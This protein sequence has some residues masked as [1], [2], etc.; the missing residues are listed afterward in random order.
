MRFISLLLAFIVWLPSLIAAPPAGM[1]EFQKMKYGFFVHYVW[2][3]AAYSA[4]ID[5]DGSKPAGLDD[6]ADR[7]DA[8]QFA[9]DLAAMKVEYVVFTAFHANMNVLYPSKVMDKWLPGHSAKRDL[10]GDMIKACK[11]KGIPVLFYTH[12]RDGHDF[13]ASEQARTGW[14]AGQSPN[15]DFGKWDRTNWNDFVNEVYGELVDRYGNDI[16]GLYLDEGSAAADSY[17][18]VDYPRLR[19]T[20]SAKHPQLLLM[21]ND[22]GDLYGFDI[23]NREVFYNGSYGTPDGNQW[24]SAKKP[25]SIVVGSIFW[26]AFPEGKTEPSQKSDK[27]GFN[28]W[29]QYSPAAMFRYTVLQAGI[30]TDGGGVLW[31]AG[32]YPG[33]GWEVG[34][35]ERMKAVGSLVEAVAPSIKNTYPSTSYPTKP[36][37]RIADLEW[38][39]ATRSTDGQREFLH[40]LTPPTG[41]TVLNLPPPADGKKFSQ[42]RLLKTGQKVAFKQTGDGLCL[43]LPAGEKWDSLDTVIALDVAAGSPPVNHAL[44]KPFRASSLEGKNYAML[45]TDGS[46]A[47]A[48]IPT[49]SDV[50]HAGYLD[51]AQ[52]CRFSRVEVIGNIPPGTRLELAE[53]FGFTKAEELATAAS[54]RSSKLEIV[55][56][57]YG[58]GDK[59][60]DLTAK[61]RTATVGGMLTVT[62][63]NSLAGHDP[64]PN[65]KK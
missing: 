27:V 37:V 45:A 47:T 54:V 14:A 7:F 39:V 58:A 4:T 13:T 42:A 30:C 48:W 20:I 31:A 29:I 16:L 65:V 36:G 10:L 33:G 50:E 53:D 18:V 43:E 57:I 44:W 63:D 25:V 32:P 35:L 22:Y 49:A 41:T 1:A 64:A 40:V 23:G 26:A 19:R 8:K 61:L 55:R 24:E 62:A 11:E 17:R 52:S 51:L 2:G 3:G 46:E 34:V 6:L 28:P 21:Q 60:A 38:G 15:P 9:A 56:A 59:I 12:P 5:K